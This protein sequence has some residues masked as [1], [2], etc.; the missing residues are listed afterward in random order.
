MQLATVQALARY[1]A[2]EYDWRKGQATL[3]AS[4]QFITEIDGLDIHFLAGRGSGF[5]NG[6]TTAPLAS[7]GGARAA[8][9][10]IDGW[11]RIADVLSRTDVAA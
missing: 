2:K 4:P 7:S 10:R 3:N 11:R 5:G 1:W 6:M 8:L 9:R